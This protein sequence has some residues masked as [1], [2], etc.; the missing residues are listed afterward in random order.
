MNNAVEMGSG[1]MVYKLSFIK[2]GSDIQKLTVADTQTN[3]V[4]RE[5][6]LTLGK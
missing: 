2:F 4:E 5:H 3:R 6:K 1:A